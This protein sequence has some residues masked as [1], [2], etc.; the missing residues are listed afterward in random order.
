MSRTADELYLLI[1]IWY[2][3]LFDS[4]QYKNDSMKELID[5]IKVGR[6]MGTQVDR[7]R[8]VIAEVSQ[9]HSGTYVCT[10]FNTA[11]KQHTYTSL[12]INSEYYQPDPPYTSLGH[13]NWQVRNIT[14]PK[15]Y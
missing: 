11:G 10:V 5:L 4:W 12:I 1:I 2:F 3:Y 9:L 14:I 15:V 6:Q 7:E 13:T 8:V